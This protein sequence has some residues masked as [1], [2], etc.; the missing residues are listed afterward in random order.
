MSRTAAKLKGVCGIYGWIHR[1]SL[2]VYVG[3]TRNMMAR[4][5][6]HRMDAAKGSQSH[7]HCA[8]RKYGEDAFDFEI[9]EYCSPMVLT[10]REHFYIRLMDS[11]KS[12]FN[13][14]STPSRSRWGV[15]VSDETR[16]KISKAAAGKKKSEAHRIAAANGQR[17]IPKSQSMKD[18]LRA[19][20]LGTKRSE[21]DCRK[22]SEGQ[23]KEVIQMDLQG[24][25]IARYASPIEAGIAMD[26]TPNC[27]R[28]AANGSYP[29]ACGFKWKYTSI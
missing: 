18:K 10:E 17:G 9:L 24:T 15:A 5:N 4:R 11:I 6:R 29:T 28:G 19:R 26:R 20:W 16:L 21:E 25:E 3:Q 13:L 2:R 22:I 8:L 14:A 27:I 1:E 12:G 23:K 7:F